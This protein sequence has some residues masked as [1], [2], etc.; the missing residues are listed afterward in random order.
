MLSVSTSF[1]APQ[2]YVIKIYYDRNIC[3]VFYHYH[4]CRRHH[5]DYHH[6]HHQISWL[7][8]KRAQRGVGWGDE[9]KQPVCSH[10]VQNEALAAIPTLDS[11]ITCT[12]VDNVNVM[13]TM[14]AF[15]S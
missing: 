12:D 4:H 9:E 11:I 13:V 1:P 8:M 7:S 15:V 6:H 3:I 2:S 14:Q 5:H 10:P